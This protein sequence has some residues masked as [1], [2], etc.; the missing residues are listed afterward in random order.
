MK[1]PS[2]FPGPA[3]IPTPKTIEV[4]PVYGTLMDRVMGAAREYRRTVSELG[5]NHASC[6]QLEDN[7]MGWVGQVQDGKVRIPVAV[8]RAMG[9]PDLALAVNARGEVA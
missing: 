2:G 1:L 3:P 6:A 7:I 8:A 9:R 4:T 5:D